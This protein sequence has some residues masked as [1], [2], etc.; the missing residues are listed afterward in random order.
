M[1]SELLNRKVTN[2]FLEKNRQHLSARSPDGFSRRMGFN[3][4]ELIWWDLKTKN[5]VEPR[6]ECIAPIVCV[7]R[8]ACGCLRWDKATNLAGWN[9]RGLE[10]PLSCRFFRPTT[11]TTTKI[12]AF[13]T[14][15]SQMSIDSV[16]Q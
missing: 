4:G 3:T 13:F 5:F 14:L 7:I 9:P 2:S 1:C 8:K 15:K 10:D 16:L 12:V 6:L 11:P